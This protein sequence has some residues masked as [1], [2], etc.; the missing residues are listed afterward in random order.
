MICEYGCE[1]GELPKFIFLFMCLCRRLPGFALCMIYMYMRDCQREYIFYFLFVFC[2]LS[3]IVFCGVIVFGILRLS[4][5]LC[6]CFGTLH[7]ELVTRRQSR[8]KRAA[9]FLC[10]RKKDKEGKEGRSCYKLYIYMVTI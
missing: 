2:I 5:V 7:G 8:S 10:T 9:C 4:M 3:M 1:Y 6:T